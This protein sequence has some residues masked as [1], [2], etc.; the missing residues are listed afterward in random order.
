MTKTGIYYPE[1]DALRFLAFLLVLFHHSPYPDGVPIWEAL[2]NYG[3]IGVDLFLCLSAYLF[4]KLLFIE[5]QKEGNINIG[6]FYLRRILRIWPLYFL[7]LTL[8]LGYSIFVNGWNT[9]ILI[10]ALGMV[11][12]TDNLLTMWNGYNVAIAY[13]AHLWTISYEEQFYLFIPWALRAL[14]RAKVTTSIYIF[15]ITILF[16]IFIR[17]IFITDRFSYLSVWVFPLTHFESILGGIIIGLGLFK[18]NMNKIP[19]WVLFLTGLFSLWLVMN[20]PNITVTQWKLMLTYPL[21]GIGTTFILTS[22]TMGGL[23][24]ISTVFKNSILGYLGKISY[25]LYVYHLGVQELTS[26]V[27]NK[28]MSPDLSLGY[29]IVFITS[30][31]IVTILVSVFSYQILEKPFLKIKR[32]FT[33]INSRPI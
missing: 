6:F 28:F 24:F 21:V 19:S 4:T 8:M 29:P 17:W 15:A 32:R 7:F 27:I 9:Q 20:L 33:F 25:G 10:R 5:Y 22:A 23:G 18:E 14:Y 30:T 11:S 26:N 13:S 12:F 16:G 31:L 2:H 3:W 1:L